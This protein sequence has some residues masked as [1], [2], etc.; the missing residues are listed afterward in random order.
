[1]KQDRCQLQDIE[2]RASDEDPCLSVPLGGH[3]GWGVCTKP[4]AQIG[5]QYMWE[6]ANKGLAPALE[7]A[8]PITGRGSWFQ[9]DLVRAET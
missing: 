6:A 4:D 9:K 1:M 8:W 3:A 2:A 5:V 7:T